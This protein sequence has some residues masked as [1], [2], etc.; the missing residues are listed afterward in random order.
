MRVRSDGPQLIS[1]MVSKYLNIDCSVLM[2][3]NIATDIG[4]EELSECVIGYSDL[5]HAKVLQKLFQTKY[6]MVHLSPDVAGAEMCGTLKNVVA[7][8]AG[9]VDG[10]GL[11][12]NSKATIL[13]QVWRNGMP[14]TTPMH[15]WY[16]V[17]CGKWTATTAAAAGPATAAAGPAIIVSFCDV[18]DPLAIPHSCQVQVCSCS[19]IPEC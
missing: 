1:Q 3:A 18:Q 7:L 19:Y 4:K 6:F 9:M 11:G 16:G 5:E 10:L 2:G 17:L 12:P 14:L 8:A 15:S 13:R